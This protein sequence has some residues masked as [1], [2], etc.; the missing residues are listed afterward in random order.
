MDDRTLN[1]LLDDWR[2]EPPSAALR[3]A[4]L[5]AAPRRGDLPWRA[6]W[7]RRGQV[8]IAGA[9]LA[10]GIAGVSCGAI[11]STAAVREARDEAL[12][13]AVVSEGPYVAP[14]PEPMHT[15]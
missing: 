9:G 5:A 1:S 15:L 7:L 6:L 3:D 13:A 10:A 14:I 12:V 4:I 2:T 8:W 11:F